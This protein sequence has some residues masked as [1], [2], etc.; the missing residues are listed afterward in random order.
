MDGYRV[1]TL[2]AKLAIDQS[3]ISFDHETRGEQTQK[4]RVWQKFGNSLGTHTCVVCG[5]A[6]A[7]GNTAERKGVQQGQWHHLVKRRYFPSTH[8][9]SQGEY[10]ESARRS[11]HHP[12]NAVLVCRGC[13]GLLE[14]YE[15]GR[16]HIMSWLCKN[17]TGHEIPLVLPSDSRVRDSQYRDWLL[18]QR[19]IERASDYRCEACGHKQQERV[20]KQVYDGDDE[21]FDYVGRDVRAVHVLPPVVAPDLMHD[22]ANL[23]TLCWECL[24]G[25]DERHSGDDPTNWSG[26]KD[27][28]PIAWVRTFAPQ[29]LHGRREEVMNA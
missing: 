11:K 14:D 18:V 9:T 13:H 28:P 16:P 26:W 7:R 23:V 5:E 4:D 2:S 24:F 1:P 19:D 25:A 12:S 17:V 29:L 6:V 3:Y 21:L 10:S 8:S 15:N 27:E 22:P 20:T